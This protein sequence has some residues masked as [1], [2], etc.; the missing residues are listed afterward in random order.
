MLVSLCKS[1]AGA[2]ININFSIIHRWVETEG[3]NNS[4]NAR[5]NEIISPSANC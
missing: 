2:N 4:T 3:A 1:Y 5:Y